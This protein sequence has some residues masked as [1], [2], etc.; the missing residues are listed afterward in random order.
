MMDLGYGSIGAWIRGLGW[1][2]RLAL[3]AWVVS[4]RNIEIYRHPDLMNQNLHFGP[5]VDF[6]LHNEISVLENVHSYI[7]VHD[8]STV[9]NSN[10][11]GDW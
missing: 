9:M 6:N 11:Y 7:R 1:Q 10:N 5:G 8:A 3:E 4:K 2:S